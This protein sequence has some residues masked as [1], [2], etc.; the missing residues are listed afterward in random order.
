[1]QIAIAS[2]KGGTGKTTVAISLALVADKPV[3]LMD[4]DVEEPNCHLFL[5]PDHMESQTMYVTVP[6]I[7]LA[8]CDFCGKCRDICA[9]KAIS[10]FGKNIM[11]FPELCHSCM[12]CFLVCPNEAIKEGKREIGVI[13][14]GSINEIETLSGTLRVG[15]AMSPPL[16]KKLRDMTSDAMLTIIDAPPGTSCPVIAATKG[17]DFTILVT[18]STPFGLND[19]KLAAKLMEKLGQK[20]GIVINKAG[21][22]DGSVEKWCAETGYPLL[23]SIP[24][25]RKLAEAYSNGI[26]IIKAAPELIPAF[27]RLLEEVTQ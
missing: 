9:F 8:K 4:C 7:D 20:F 10:V 14:Q 27:K 19:L 22:G 25:D 15:E 21:I 1:M 16:I 23:L 11:T 2:G 5:R 17:A 3:R 24:F 13:S 26:P 18:E 12:G 6:E